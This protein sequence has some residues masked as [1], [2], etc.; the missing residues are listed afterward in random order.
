MQHGIQSLPSISGGT[1]G[2][3]RVP[4]H[5]PTAMLEQVQERLRSIAQDMY[6]LNRSCGEEVARSSLARARKAAPKKKRRARRNRVRPVKP[7]CS[8]TIEESI[9]STDELA[10]Q[11]KHAR[12]TT[13]HHP[14]PPRT[15]RSTPPATLTSP[16]PIPTKAPLTAQSFTNVLNTRK[17]GG[18]AGTRVEEAQNPGPATHARDWTVT[19]QPNASHRR[20]NEAGDSVPSSQDS[21]TRAVQNVHI[22]DSPAAPLALPAPPPPTTRNAR[23]PP[24]PKQQPR[25]YFRCAQCGPVADAHSA[26]R[27]QMGV[28][29]SIQGRS[30]EVRC[31]MQRVWDNCA[32]SIARPV[33]LAGPSGRC[34]V[35]G[36]TA[37]G[38][39]FSSPREGHL[40]GQTTAR[41]SGRCGQWY[42]S[43]S[44]TSP[45]LA[46]SASRRTFE[47]QPV[48]ELPHPGSRS[49]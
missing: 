32:G 8:D 41:A 24:R 6:I 36:A 17:F 38:A 18:Y 9:S 42:G 33:L 14:A 10:P 31:R 3:R 16:F 1:L 23:R 39:I 13:D 4:T 29:C 45:E 19:E 47:R 20:I 28:S 27:L 2:V 44:A 25:E 12:S 7:A 35:A 34:D 21:V 22:S 46:A 49:D 5:S 40:P 15:S 43:P 26:R 11:R 37:A 48:S 30:T